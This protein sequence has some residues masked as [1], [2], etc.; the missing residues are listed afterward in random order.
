MYKLTIGD[1]KSVEKNIPQQCPL[2]VTSKA[3]QPHQP[4]RLNWLHWLACNFYILE[5]RNFLG[6]F[7][8]VILGYRTQWKGRAK[9][10]QTL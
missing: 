3:A 6:F 1:F 7:V 9:N 4:S 5:L 2:G 10:R 8:L